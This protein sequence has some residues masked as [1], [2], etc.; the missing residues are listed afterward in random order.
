MKHR[1]NTFIQTLRQKGLTV[2]FA[3]SVTCGMATQKLGSCAGASEVLAGS[4]VCYTPEVKKNLFDISQSM[5]DRYT[6]ESREVTH[7]LA[8]KLS[9]LIK[10]DIYAAV[11]G[12]ASAG[13]SETTGKPVGTIFF[14]VRYRNRSYDY[15]KVFRGSPFT[16]R[17]KASFELYRLIL[18]TIG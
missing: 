6:C 11:T 13:G 10:A 1:A 5:I 8:A 4:V 2:A 7:A 15:R 16:I 12:L 9:T 14:S 17:E 18:D 3:E